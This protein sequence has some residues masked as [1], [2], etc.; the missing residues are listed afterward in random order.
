MQTRSKSLRGAT[1]PDAD[2][3]SEAADEVETRPTRNSPSPPKLTLVETPVMPVH[4]DVEA[5]IGTSG[6]VRRSP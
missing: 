4:H 6:E 1:G 5:N 2:A 3:A